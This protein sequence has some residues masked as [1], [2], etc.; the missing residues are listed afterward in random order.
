MGRF[1]G[2][3]S[4]MEYITDLPGNERTCIG[5][6]IWKGRGAFYDCPKGGEVVHRAQ[7][8]RCHSRKADDSG[9]RG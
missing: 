2:R 9:R 3:R 8:M 5:C 7:V 4:L 1:K 6:S